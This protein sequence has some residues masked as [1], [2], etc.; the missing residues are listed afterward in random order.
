LLIVIIGGNIPMKTTKL[1]ERVAHCAE[2]LEHAARLALL[3][4]R[5]HH[6]HYGAEYLLDTI[7]DLAPELRQLRSDRRRHDRRR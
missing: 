1:R 7:D 3:A 5:G 2:R 4:A 6:P